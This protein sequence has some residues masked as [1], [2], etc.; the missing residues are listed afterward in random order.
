MGL[1]A[2]VDG[3]WVRLGQRAWCGVAS[4]DTRCDDQSS[5]LWLA[6]E[7]CEP[8]RFVFRDRPRADAGAV[9]REL[10]ASGLSVE[11]LSGDRQ[12]AVAAVA[13]ELGISSW[14]AAMTPTA[15]VAYLEALASEGHKV[16]MVGDG[17][18]DAPALAAAHA[19]MSP[20]RAADISRTAA[21]VIFQGDRLSPVLDALRIAR[22][23]RR[24]VLQNFGLAFAYNLVAV[25]LAIAGMVTPLIAA[26]AMSA[27]SLLVTMNALRLR[28]QSGRVAP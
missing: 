16:L 19:S 2:L 23:A 17:L 27:S 7:G 25:P 18:N 12:A 26:A 1:E 10:Q 15:K 5:E 8:R 4:R 22:I 28:L 24:L 14:R 21:D 11:L 9:I 13:D 3:A 6:R 20:A